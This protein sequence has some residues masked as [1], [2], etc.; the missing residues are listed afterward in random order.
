[1]NV[2]ELV[3]NRFAAIAGL[4]VAEIDP[5]ADLRDRYGI[6]SVKAL[7][8]ISEVEVEFDVDIEQEEARNIRTLADL[9]QMI[10]AKRESPAVQDGR[11]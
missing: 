4:P 11:R 1:M 9:L 8:L 7:K 6:D 5:D 2:E 3:K 10:D